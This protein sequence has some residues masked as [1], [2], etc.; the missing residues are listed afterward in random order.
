MASQP[1]EVGVSIAGLLVDGVDGTPYVGASLFLDPDRGVSLHVPFL[2]FEGDGQEGGQF[3]NVRQW[4]F[5]D[6]VPL[7]MLFRSHKGDFTLCDVKSAGYS[8][9]MFLGEG[10]LRVGEAVSGLRSHTVALDEPLMVKDFY[11]QLKGL[12][13]WSRLTAASWTPEVDEQGKVIR[14]NGVVET[15][16]PRSWSQGEALMTLTSSW[17]SSSEA[18]GLH[19]NEW[20]VL[21]SS[22]PTPQPVSVHLAEHRKFQSF[23]VMMIGKAV[24]FSKHQLK[25]E[26]FARHSV[27]GTV[28]DNPFRDVVVSGTVSEHQKPAPIGKSRQG[29][30]LS[31]NEVDVDGLERWASHYESW[32]RFVLPAVGLLSRQ[33]VFAEDRVSSLA[34][35]LEAAGNLIGVVEGEDA[36]YTNRG[37]KTTATW[38]FRCLTYLG[39][40][41]SAFADT[42]AGLAQ[43]IA[44]NYNTIKHFD[45]G[46]FPDLSETI[47]V[48]EVVELMVRYLAL[49]LAKPEHAFREGSGFLFRSLADDFNR[50]GLRVD[51]DGQ[52]VEVGAS[53][54]S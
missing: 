4:F 11:S 5:H 8:T 35:S 25:D 28:L 7:N 27:G 37:R 43:A 32:G 54:E 2:G 40:D 1:L 14:L 3:E 13:E 23:L 9:N 15:V 39:W 46:D 38:F 21:K 22:F 6:A 36:T 42:T 45:R 16:A 50:W 24:P 12:F 10:R 52:W 31:F 51:A 26:A 29:V 53:T 44:D 47:L 18:Q 30:L 33:G 34:M 17:T 20:T 19:V 48:G 49:K 41:C